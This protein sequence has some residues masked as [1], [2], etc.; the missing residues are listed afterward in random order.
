MKFKYVGPTLINEE[1]EEEAVNTYGGGKAMFG[2]VVEFDDN[3]SKKALTN[4]NYEQVKT[5]NKKPKVEKEPKEL[6][7][8]SLAIAQ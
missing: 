4:P 6:E 1:G 5:R 2:D 7:I 3:L 8:D